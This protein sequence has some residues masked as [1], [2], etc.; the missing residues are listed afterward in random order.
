MSKKRIVVVCPGRGSYTKETLGYLKNHPLKDK[1]FLVKLDEWR[2]SISEPTISELDNADSFKVSLHTKGEHASPLIYAA[3]YADFLS[4]NREKY[5]IAA[6]C[7]NS[8]GWYL[9]LAFSGALDLSGAFNVIQTMGSMMKENI[10][11]AQL[12]YPIINERWQKSEDKRNLVF[13]VLGEVNELNNGR[14]YVS[15]YLG[16]YI[17]IAGDVQAIKDVQQRLPKDGD[18]P[19]QLINHAA[20]H[21][22]LL[23]ATSK[24]AFQLLSDSLFMPPEVPIIDGE[25]R[26]WQPYSTNTESLYSYTLGTQ[27][28]ATYDFTKSVTVA[29]KEFAPD[30][31]VLL[32]PGNSLGGA[33][34]QILIENTWCDIKTKE[35]FQE[36]QKHDPFIL[37]MGLSSQ[38]DILL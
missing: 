12:I 24:K 34:G 37:S 20:F 6:I 11:G 1:P 14:V 36:R 19:F 22:P 28:V 26:I 27:V 16:G 17:V 2:K 30:H 13:K 25:G 7:G 4:I 32:G 23:E 15:I 38:R 31:L 35:D 29:L 5:E 3:A 9:T 10:I 8:M 21:T 33:L 18:Y